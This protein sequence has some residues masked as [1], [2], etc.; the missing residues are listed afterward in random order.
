MAKTKSTNLEKHTSSNPLQ[1]FLINRFQD[2]VT[3]E[4]IGLKP[5]SMM[6]VGCGEG[7]DLKHILKA[8]KPKKTVGVDID[9]E[10]VKYAQKHLPK[11]EF[12]QADAKK[13]PFKKNQFDLVLALEIIE[14]IPD[15]DEAIS[16]LKR[17]SKGPV[18]I[19]VPWEP[20]FSVVGLLRGK[21]LNRLGRHPEHVNAW[22]K[23]SFAKVVKK[24]GLKIKN[25]KIIFPWQMVILEK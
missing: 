4:V 23:T 13:L 2:I 24:H 25:H 22:N 6:S 21:Y 16:E 19:T 17:V 7:F 20:W 14:H 18:L 10:A 3:Q 9:K 5:E 12:R 11:V 8:Y 15:Y 1:K